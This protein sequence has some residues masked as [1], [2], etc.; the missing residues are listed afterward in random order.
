MSKKVGREQ[1]FCGKLDERRT[2]A[3]K[4]EHLSDAQRLITTEQ[5]QIKRDFEE[6]ESFINDK[7]RKI[8]RHL[9]N[10]TAGQQRLEELGG[11]CVA[12]LESVLGAD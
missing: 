2:L 9:S 8:Q 10:I 6:I 1:N 4:L 3:V 12:V 7:K 11:E 5:G